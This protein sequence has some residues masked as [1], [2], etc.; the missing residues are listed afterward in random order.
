[1]P[2][3]LL[4]KV[5]LSVARIWLMSRLPQVQYLT[6][7]LTKVGIIVSPPQPSMTAEGDAP[8]AQPLG[9]LELPQGRP[10]ASDGPT[11]QGE[12]AT[13]FPHAL[14]VGNAAVAGEHCWD[15][16]NHWDP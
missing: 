10:S 6:Q 12:G 11:R 9:S 16:C 1:M 7:M 5:N 3:V 2:L 14:S 13:N 8:S 4:C 15:F